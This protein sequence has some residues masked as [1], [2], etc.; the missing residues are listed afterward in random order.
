[1]AQIDTLAQQFELD[2]PYLRGVAY[3]ML[4]SFDD[5]EDAVQDA[6]LRASAAKVGRDR[7]RARLADHHRQPR[8]PEHVARPPH[9]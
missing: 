9:T 5:A 8:L 6:W 2:R 3:R 7:K 1:M 4:G